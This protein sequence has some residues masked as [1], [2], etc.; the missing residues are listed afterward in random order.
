[1]P[2]TKNQKIE[3]VK[4]VAEKVNETKTIVLA[5]FTG[6]SANGMNT[7]RARLHETGMKF[8]VIKKRLL[9]RVFES[10]GIDINPEEV[11]GQLGIVMSQND[12]ADT[13]QPIYTFQ[14]EHKETFKIMGGCEV[15]EKNVLGAEEVTRIGALP[16]REVLIGQLVGM[17]ASPIKSFLFV[18]NEKSKMVEGE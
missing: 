18:L 13:A 11:E 16:S 17:F 15:V 14:E 4:E 7:F 1:M 8:R 3:E 10:T 9:K 5:D 6:L 12:I 2:K